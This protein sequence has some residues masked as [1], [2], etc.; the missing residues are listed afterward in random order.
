VGFVDYD[1]RAVLSASGVGRRLL[2]E[3]TPYVRTEIW[4]AYPRRYTA[5][6][7]GVSTVHSS[8]GMC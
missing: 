5:V 7:A 6:P 1:V 3:D 8:A 2:E 4:V